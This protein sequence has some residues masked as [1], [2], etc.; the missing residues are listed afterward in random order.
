MLDINLYNKLFNVKIFDFGKYTYLDL[1]KETKKSARAMILQICKNRIDYHEYSFSG[2]Y[3][4]IGKGN[5][6]NL[7]LK[8]HLIDLYQRWR[9]GKIFPFKTKLEDIRKNQPII[10]NLKNVFIKDKKSLFPDDTLLYIQ[11]F[12]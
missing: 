10:F 3:V 12:I 9:E 8:H 5:H 6:G 7:V 2:I 1:H 11:I 4:N